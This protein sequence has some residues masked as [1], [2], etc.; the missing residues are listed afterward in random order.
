GWGEFAVHA[1]RQGIRVHGVTI[2]QAQYALAAERVAR[3]GL[4]DRVTLELRDYRDVDGQYDAIVSIEMFEAVGE[5]F[6]P[7]YFDTLRQRLKPGARAL[8]QSITIIESL[9][10]A[11]RTSSDFIRE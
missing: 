11:Y 10:D 7:V 8:I 3:D 4:S 9:F 2:S 6:W 5:T 1:A